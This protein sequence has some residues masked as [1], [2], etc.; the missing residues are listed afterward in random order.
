MRRFLDRLPSALAFKGEPGP[1]IE[2]AAQPE[3]V[4]RLIDATVQHRRVQMRYASA[5]SRRAK[6]YLVEPNRVVYGRGAWYLL[7]FVP[8]YQETRTFA[9]ARIERVTTL[10]ETFTPRDEPAEAFAHSLGIHQGKPVRVVLSFD[11]GVAPYVRERRWH[12]SQTVEDLPDGSIRLTLRV[13]DDWALRAW[14]LG[15]GSMVRVEAPASLA[16]H[17]VRELGIALKRYRDEEGPRPASR[18]RRHGR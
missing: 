3:R 4:R 12:P 6:D 8:E 13:S 11:P 7:A 16:A 14:V 1:A 15:F 2:P 9:L 18:G 10:E 17:V 5:S